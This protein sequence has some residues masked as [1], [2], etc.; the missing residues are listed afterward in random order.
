MTVSSF[1]NISVLIHKHCA[2]FEWLLMCSRALCNVSRSSSMRDSNSSTRP[3]DTSQSGHGE[4]GLVMASG[5]CR[6]SSISRKAHPARGRRR[7]SS[8]ASIPVFRIRRQTEKARAG[9]LKLRIEASRDCISP[10]SPVNK[11]PAQ[12]SFW[13]DFHRVEIERVSAL[14]RQLCTIT[15]LQVY[16]SVPL[17]WRSKTCPR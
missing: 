8:R 7:T 5:S 10:T 2:E 13:R 6:A 15:P 12:I 17:T 4:S 11:N 1:S 3:G 9:R 16:I 14:Q